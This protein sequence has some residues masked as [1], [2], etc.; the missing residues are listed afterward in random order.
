MRGRLEFGYRS[1]AHAETVARSLRVDDDKYI[2]T[3]VEGRRLVAEAEADSL[4][5][6]LHT[7]DDYLAC[8]AVAEKILKR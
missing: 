5:S 4:L 8:V 1:K 6:L 3:K 2:T 7:L